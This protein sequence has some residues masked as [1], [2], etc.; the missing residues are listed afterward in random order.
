[1]PTERT[2]TSPAGDVKEPLAELEVPFSPEQV[3]WRVTNTTNDKKRGQVV[4]YA[5]P[6][7]YTDRLNALLSPQG[8]TREYKVETVSNLTRMKRG[9]SI[10]SGKVL[11]TC[12][13]TIFGLWS[14]SGT[15]E[16]WADDGNSVTSADAQAFKRACSC[17]GLGRYFYD[18]PAIWVDLD[19]NRQPAKT[20]VLSAWALPE[21][22][23]KGMRPR[24]RN[25]DGDPRAEVQ[26]K[27]P[28]EGNDGG[29]KKAISRRDNGNNGESGHGPAEKSGSSATNSDD[30]LDQRILGMEKAVGT[31]FYHNI[32]RDYGRVNQPKLIRDVAVKQKVLMML[33]SVARG[34]DRLE[35]VLKRIDPNTVQALLTKLQ[36]SSLGQ[37]A[38]I[39]TLQNVVLGLEELTGSNP[40]HAA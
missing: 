38:D 20:P 1:M 16:E 40:L 22:W 27:G 3:Q 34:I 25:S 24:A 18:V 35:A 6:R 28:K 31:A 19:Q 12:T 15:G 30:E 36:V 7:A 14:H 21:N 10:L 13:V 8:W 9:E 33:E 2:N 29:Q 4:P 26:G 17:F 37:I 23:R 5:D 39:K 11:V 32:L